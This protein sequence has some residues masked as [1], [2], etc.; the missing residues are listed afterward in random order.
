MCGGFC[1]SYLRLIFSSRFRLTT[2]EKRVVERNL[3]TMQSRMVA[4]MKLGCQT[5]FS[6]RMLIPRKRKMMQSL[7]DANVLTAYL[8]VVKL[9]WLMFWKA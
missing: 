6:V 4:M 5:C 9:F 8:T 7:V 3:K 2:A 1:W